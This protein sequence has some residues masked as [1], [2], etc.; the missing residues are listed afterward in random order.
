MWPSIYEGSENLQNCTILP[1]FVISSAI[2]SVERSFTLRPSGIRPSCST[3][4]RN[5]RAPLIYL[6]LSA[7]HWRA[8]AAHSQNFNCLDKTVVKSRA[9]RAAHT[10]E[11]V[12]V[13]RRGTQEDKEDHTRD[14]ARSPSRRCCIRLADSRNVSAAATAAATEAGICRRSE[15]IKPYYTTDSARSFSYVR[16]FVA[17]ARAHRRGLTSSMRFNATQWTFF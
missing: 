17:R 16:L 3:E 5:A 6:L 14:S 15:I 1:L 2:H 4:R 8:Q 7:R 9:R 11:D 12:H 10:H 13:H